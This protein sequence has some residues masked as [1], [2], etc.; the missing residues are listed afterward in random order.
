MERRNRNNNSNRRN[1]NNPNPNNS[2]QNSRNRRHTQR[3]RIRTNP[4]NRNNL[5][6][7]S[8][9]QRRHSPPLPG[10]NFANNSRQNP[11]DYLIFGR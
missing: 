6:D 7:I 8:S 9:N 1:R 11:N 3:N 5:L 2:N 10:F 4:I